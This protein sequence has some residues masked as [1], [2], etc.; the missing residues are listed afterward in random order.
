MSSIHYL[1]KAFRNETTTIRFNL[2]TKFTIDS[3]ASLSV[4]IALYS[5]NRERRG[6]AA[7]ILLGRTTIHG[8]HQID[9]VVSWLSVH[10]QQDG[11][12]TQYPISKDVANVVSD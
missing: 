4:S 8:P 3:V 12:L 10:A 5:I 1:L 2:T 7:S 11:D 6:T 9:M